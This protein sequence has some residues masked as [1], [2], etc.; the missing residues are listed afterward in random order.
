[1]SLNKGRDTDVPLP[2]LNYTLIALLMLVLVGVLRIG[3]ASFN[4]TTEVVV[5]GQYLT[6]HPS[7]YGLGVVARTDFLVTFNSLPSFVPFGL[8]KTE[9]ALVDVTIVVS[10]LLTIVMLLII[11][12]S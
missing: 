11:L 3:L 1:V 5:R 6:T 4:T 8:I 10:S 12:N 7:P 9:G 2:N